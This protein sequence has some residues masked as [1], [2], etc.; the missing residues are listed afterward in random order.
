MEGEWV[1][2]VGR[3]GVLM[4][5]LVLVLV[6]IWSFRGGRGGA[7]ERW[8]YDDD[9][10]FFFRLAVFLFDDFSL[11]LFFLRH[12]IM[13]TTTAAAPQGLGFGWPGW[14]VGFWGERKGLG[15]DEGWT[16]A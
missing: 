1:E 15:M 16:D 3:G 2:W 12:A 10:G 13:T 4:P 8:F 9:R 11:T 7:G 6:W 14:L 5:R